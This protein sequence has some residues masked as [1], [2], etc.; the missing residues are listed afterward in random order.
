[1]QDNLRLWRH[2][3]CR[4][5]ILLSRK[6]M[7]QPSK[8]Q[9]WGQDNLLGFETSLKNK[10]RT[11]PKSVCWQQKKVTSD[12]LISP[13]I[14]WDYE[15]YLR[16]IGKTLT[17]LYFLLHK[18]EMTNTGSVTT[19]KKKHEATQVRCLCLTLLPVRR[20]VLLCCMSQTFQTPARMPAPHLQEKA[21]GAKYTGRSV[22]ECSNRHPALSC[23]LGHPSELSED[24]QIP[25]LAPQR[26]CT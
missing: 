10:L 9:P 16:L 4:R 2:F 19:G 17:V 22:P 25:A 11:Q 21:Q 26:A 24:I 18:L 3:D 1:M 5:F 20:W 13:W 14:I 8:Q 12:Y 6:A 23:N 7:G 15:P